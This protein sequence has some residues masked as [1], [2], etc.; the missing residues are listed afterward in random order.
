MVVSTVSKGSCI[1]LYQG[2]QVDRSCHEGK[3]KG[4]IKIVLSFLLDY[5]DKYGVV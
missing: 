2:R 4:D 1:P 5:L 3:K